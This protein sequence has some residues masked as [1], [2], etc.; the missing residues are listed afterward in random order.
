M[1][2]QIAKSAQIGK[3]CRF[4]PGVIVEDDVEISEGCEIGAFSILYRGTKIGPRSIVSPHCI[5]GMPVKGENRDTV[6]GCDALIRSGTVI[7]AGVAAGNNLVTGHF[8]LIR[9]RTVLGN[10]VLIGTHAVVDGDARIGNEVSLQTGVYITRFTVI[11]EGVFFGPYAKTCNDDFRQVTDQLQ[12]PTLEKG[13]RVG[14]NAVILPRVQVGIGAVIAA[15]AVVTKDIPPGVTVAGV[16][17]RFL[18]GRERK[19]EH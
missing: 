13:V 14:C 16:P 2:P 3:D 4:N 12:G 11:D 8:A 10:K 17:A 5:L 19:N 15:G 6:I 9:E 1:E 18:C 7:Y